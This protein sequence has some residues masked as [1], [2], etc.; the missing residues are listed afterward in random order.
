MQFGHLQEFLTHGF[1]CT[2]FKQHIIGYD[3]RRPPVVFEHG[4]NMLQEINLLV[5]S[6]RPKIL[7]VIDKIFG[8]S[9]TLGIGN[10]HAAFFAE[11]RIG[12][13]QVHFACAW[14]NQ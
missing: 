10:G 13:N 14:R 3:N 12:Q 4:V 7:A 2:A 8:F 5:G 11:W 1:A 9:F 6:R